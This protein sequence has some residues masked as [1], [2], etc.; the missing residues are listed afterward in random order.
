ML[1]LN[2]AAL[3]LT[4]TCHPALYWYEYLITLDQEITLFWTRKI[5]GATV[6]FFCNRYLS[7]FVTIYQFPWLI[8]SMNFK[9]STARREPPS[10]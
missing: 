6:L 3:S 9:V 10:S 1:N 8:F 5:T 7:L 4:A 2:E